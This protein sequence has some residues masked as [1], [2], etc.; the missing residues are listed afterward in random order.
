MGWWGC[1]SGF[2][3]C[4]WFLTQIS[5]FFSLFLLFF[6]CP[7]ILSQIWPIPITGGYQKEPQRANFDVE[8]S[9]L[10]RRFFRRRIKKPLKYRRR[11]NVEI[12]TTVEISTLFRRPSKYSNVFQ[13]FFDD[14]RNFD[15]DS[16]LNQRRKCPLGILYDI[17][18]LNT[19]PYCVPSI[20]L[21]TLKLCNLS[22]PLITKQLH[23]HL[24]TF[25]KLQRI[26]LSNLSKSCFNF[27]FIWAVSCVVR[28]RVRNTRQLISTNVR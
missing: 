8:F 16:T 10:F 6:P 3:F 26:F 20:L 25:L 12:S 14:R 18:L 22:W 28:D 27:A 11:I 13:R 21:F 4:S 19:K 9:T 24:K 5:S 17:T 2:R 7:H 15:V 1:S 23:I